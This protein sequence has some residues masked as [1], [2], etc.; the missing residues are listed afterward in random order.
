[1]NRR[2]LLI[3][4]PGKVGAENYC[5]GVY[6]DKANYYA[7]FKQA[8]GGYWAESEMRYLDKPSKASVAREMTNLTS[9]NVEFS[10]IIFCGHGW[11]SSVSHSNILEL[12]DSGEEID[13]N[14]LRAGANKRIIILD[15]CRKVYNQYITESFE[16]ALSASALYEKKR[17]LLDPEQCKRYYNKTVSECPRQLI[18]AHGCDLNET[19]GDSSSL[20]GYYSSSLIKASEKLVQEKLGSI[21]LSKSYSAI[22]FP[23]CHDKAATMVTDM[24]GGTQHPQI[25]KPRVSSSND[26][27]PFAIV[28]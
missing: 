5:A 2:I 7:Y 20:G 9:D 8:Y 24:S 22:R 10:I 18:V 16:K 17:G 1:M 11:Y 25:E 23:A 26:Y 13:S 3:T 12:N 15:S 6:K 21:D 14:V 27:L 4:N 28:A 19:A